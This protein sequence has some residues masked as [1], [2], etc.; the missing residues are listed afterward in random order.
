LKIAYTLGEEHPGRS[1][2]PTDSGPLAAYNADKDR[3]DQ[4]TNEIAAWREKNAALDAEVATMKASVVVD[5]F[6]NHRLQS[7]MI[8]INERVQD[9]SRELS[10]LKGGRPKLAE[11]AFTQSAEA[12]KLKDDITTVAKSLALLI[13]DEDRLRQAFREETGVP[14]NDRRTLS[15]H[16]AGISVESLALWLER[17]GAGQ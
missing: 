9:L 13:L 2:V 15:A 6:K 4:L 12:R 3:I 14:I 7:Q 10:A 8:A 5:Q 1:L 16:V 11:E 17:Q